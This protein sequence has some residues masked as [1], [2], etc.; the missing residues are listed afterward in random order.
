MPRASA[1]TAK[2]SKSN[3]RRV[4]TSTWPASP[5]SIWSAA[6]VLN[7]STRLTRFAETSCSEKDWPAAVKMLR[8]LSVVSASGRP[9]I[10]M[11]AASPWPRS[12]T[13]MPV[14]RWSASTTLL[15]GNLPT[16][17]ATIES[18]ICTDSRRRLIAP[19]IEARTPVTTTSSGVASSAGVATSAA[20]VPPVVSPACCSGVP[21]WPGC[22]GFACAKA[23][24]AASSDSAETDERMRGLGA[25]G[26]PL[27]TCETP[28]RTL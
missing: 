13:W 25:I 6:R 12:V 23:G 5:V 19:T 24:V 7:T 11:P 10:W 9:R 4:T 21:G 1:D 20:G 2:P 3:G 15:S 22:S 27:M 14:T 28:A 18:T 8:P 16:S 26:S 17:S